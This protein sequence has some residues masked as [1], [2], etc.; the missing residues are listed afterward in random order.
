MGLDTSDQSGQES[1]GG[2]VKMQILSQ[3]VWGQPGPAT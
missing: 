1:S 3:Q 2:L